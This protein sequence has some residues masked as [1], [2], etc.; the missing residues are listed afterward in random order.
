MYAK[1]KLADGV[2]IKV[3]ITSE[4]LYD[5][6]PQCGKEHNIFFDDL[7]EI[8]ESRYFCGRCSSDLKAC[9]EASK[10]V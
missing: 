4:N 1:A 10:E 9:E 2:E 7:A 6:C 5:V 8:I 3:E